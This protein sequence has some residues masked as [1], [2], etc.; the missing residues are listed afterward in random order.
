MSRTTQAQQIEQINEH[1]AMCFFEGTLSALPEPGRLQGIRYPLRTVVVTALMAMV[2]GCDDAEAMESWGEEN[3]EW[4]GGFLRTRESAP[5][6]VETTSS[7]C[8]PGRGVKRRCLKEIAPK[9][10]SADAPSLRVLVANLER[11]VSESLGTTIR[12]TVGM[13]VSQ[14]MVG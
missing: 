14:S 8:S 10:E 9:R 3:A 11:L 2:C 1:Q 7:S 12:S 13:A 6:G 4:L 5:A